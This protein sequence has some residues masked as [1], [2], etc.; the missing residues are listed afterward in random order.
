M[1]DSQFW[2]KLSLGFALFSMFFGAGNVIFPL[3]L[4]KIVGDQLPLALAGLL[5]TAVGLPFMGVWIVSRLDGNPNPFFR[6]FGNLPSKVIIATL[7]LLL[8]PLGS[9]PR[10]IALSYATM[11]DSLGNPSSYL[12]SF[13]S[14]VVLFFLCYRQTRMLSWLSKVWT[15]MLLASLLFLLIGGFVVAPSGMPDLGVGKVESFWLGLSEGYNTMDLLAAFFFAPLLFVSLG[16]KKG[17]DGATTRRFVQKSS[18]IG[19]GLLAI[20]YLGFS[21]L[22]AKMAPSLAGVENA[23]ILKFISYQV[24]GKY[25][26][27]L[28]NL[29]VAFACFT[30]AMALACVFA[31]YLHEQVFKRKLPFAGALAITL[32][33]TGAV[34]SL[35]FNGIAHFLGPVL[36]VVYPLV[37]AMGIIFLVALSKKKVVSSN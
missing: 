19:I 34:A 5:I 17:W 9:T 4:G 15:P 26:A 16:D 14:C 3:L 24:A 6:Y 8:G 31:N 36:Q 30:T 32:V 28:L 7:M 22:S 11:R 25:G 18:I 10:C 1:K 33:L 13:V 12:F 2:Q 35:E 21:A 20:F 29:V 23:E 37:I 27:I